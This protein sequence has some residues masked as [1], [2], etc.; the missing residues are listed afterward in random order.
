MSILGI[1]EQ[2]SDTGVEIR[3]KQIEKWIDTL[4]RANVG[5]T[6]KLVYKNLYLINRTELSEANRYKILE[7]FWEPTNFLSEALKKHFLGLPFPLP[8]KKQQVALLARE[9]LAEMA[10][11]YKIIVEG[12]LTGQSSRIDNKMLV[13]SSYHAMQYLG[14]VLLRSYQ[15]YA[16]VPGNIWKQ[17]Y[18]LCLHAKQNNFDDTPTTQ[19]N[20]DYIS[21]PTIKNLFKQLVLLSLASPYRLGQ[22]DIEKVNVFLEQWS[23]YAEFNDVTNSE[24]QT[25]MF[26]IDYSHNE[27]PGFFVP[28]EHQSSLIQVL[29]TSELVAAIRDDIKHYS[30]YVSTHGGN[31]NKILSKKV[32]KTLLLTWGGI[33]K[34]GFSRSKSNLK[35]L[36]T[37]GLSSTHHII[38]ETMK[39]A[40]QED[41]ERKIE[42]NSDSDTESAQKDAWP[43]DKKTQGKKDDT[44][45]EYK[46]LDLVEP[47]YN[48]KSHFT[49]IPAFGISQP[50]SGKQD[51]WSQSYNTNIVDYDDTIFSLSGTSDTDSFNASSPSI[52]YETHICKSV[53]ESAGGF[54]LAWE[55]TSTRKSPINALVG[56]LVGI[57]ELTDDEDE[58]LQWGIGVIRWMK[59]SGTSQLELGIQKLAPHA[60]SAGTFIVKKIKT[61]GPYLRTLVL[62]EIKTLNQPMTLIAPGIYSVGN[63][64]SLSI[65]GDKVLIQLTKLLDSTGSFSH[66][67]FAGISEDQIIDENDNKHGI[68]FDDVWSSIK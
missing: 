24:A 34:R 59:H 2:K 43:P 44:P 48:K 65:F 40:I 25:G 6:A 67:Q 37:F 13:S 7:Q 28:S 62:P 16:P 30:S 35:V 17:I 33:A 21:Q 58:E 57:R 20:K 64:L 27:P 9:T 10:I 23:S 45:D 18:R 5:E 54:R 55:T 50:R 31:K 4:P 12:K 22:G 47:V 32:L 8:A 26:S 29:D 14:A 39:S 68:D 38:Y 61:P 60:I 56:E 66:F 51:V 15:I 41:M 11:G 1:P 63:T 49:S 19:V 53:N 42:A 3:P 36:V 46:N 52:Q